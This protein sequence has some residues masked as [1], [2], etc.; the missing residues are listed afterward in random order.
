MNYDHSK[1]RTNENICYLLDVKRQ[2]LTSSFLE[3]NANS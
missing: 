1:Q 3:I 2:S